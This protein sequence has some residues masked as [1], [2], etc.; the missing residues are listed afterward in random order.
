MLIN[1]RKS[2]PFNWNALLKVY[3]FAYV[4]KMQTF[5]KQIALTVSS[6]SIMHRSLSSS[7]NINVSYPVRMPQEHG[8]QFSQSD[9]RWTRSKNC[10]PNLG[11][12]MQQGF[13]S[14]CIGFRRNPKTL[15]SSEVLRRGVRLD[16]R[17]HPVD[18]KAQ[19]RETCS[20]Y[21]HDRQNCTRQLPI[22]NMHSITFVKCEHKKKIS[23]QEPTLPIS[24]YLDLTTRCSSEIR[25][26]TTNRNA[27]Q[28][29]DNFDLR[30]MWK[31]TL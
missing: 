1:G 13:G 31:V 2:L 17:Q 24:D 16:H 5:W 3:W 9:A 22:A 7:G 6:P 29:A 10:K 11:K 19:R 4:L 30:L 21:G 18:R 12:L 28:F 8:R 25:W 27:R 15:K 23:D 20:N 26:S 14:H